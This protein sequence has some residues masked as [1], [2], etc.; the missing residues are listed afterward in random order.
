M[1]RCDFARKC[2][3]LTLIAVLLTAFLP[4]SVLAQ[5]SAGDACVQGTADGETADT[6][7]WFVAGCALGLTGWLIAYVVDPSPPAGSMIG[8]DSN[9]TMQYLSCYKTSAKAK[10]S[11]A[12]LTGCAVSTAAWVIVYA[13]IIASAD[14]LNDPYY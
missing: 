3:A 12:A 2:I 7:I 6:A 5:E 10:Q 9:Y 4:V 13:I 11:K 8:K 1:T 14:D